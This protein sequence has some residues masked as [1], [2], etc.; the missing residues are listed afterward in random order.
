GYAIQALVALES[1]AEDEIETEA[2]ESVDKSIANREPQKLEVT[3][4][5]DSHSESATSESESVGT[6]SP[7]DKTDPEQPASVD[8]VANVESIVQRPR[9]MQFQ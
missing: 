4:S 1:L 8:E 7:E 2:I 5:Q 3:D 6:E 9:R